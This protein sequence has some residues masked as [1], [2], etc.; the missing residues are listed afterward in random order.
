MSDLCVP[1][2]E[3]GLGELEQPENLD[4]V[5]CPIHVQPS[6]I[7]LVKVR[8]NST[9]TLLADFSDRF[10]LLVVCWLRQLDEDEFAVPTILIIEVQTAWAVEPDPAKKSKMISS[11]WS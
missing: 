5:S 2:G 10:E 9:H 3:V 7:L 6:S 11:L 8:C 4:P 1:G